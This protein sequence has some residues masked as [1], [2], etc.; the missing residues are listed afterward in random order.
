VTNSASIANKVA[1]LGNLFRRQRLVVRLLGL[2][3]V[4]RHS[5]WGQLVGGGLAAAAVI[6]RSS[7]R[8]RRRKSYYFLL[9][10]VNGD[11]RPDGE[12]EKWDRNGNSLIVENGWDLPS[13]VESEIA[14]RFPRIYT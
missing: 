1:L 7:F 6:I 4:V 8:R 10:Y 2:L 3:L 14:A 11:C 9:Q 12:W 13:W 5:C